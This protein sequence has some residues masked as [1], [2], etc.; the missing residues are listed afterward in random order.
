MSR[1]VHVGVHCPCHISPY[2][3]ICIPRDPL[4]HVQERTCYLH[5]AI[6]LNIRY[7]DCAIVSNVIMSGNKY[8]IIYR[9]E[10]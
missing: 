3:G 4:M 9:H 10:A 8:V 6:V 7:R 5:T 2:V 1:T